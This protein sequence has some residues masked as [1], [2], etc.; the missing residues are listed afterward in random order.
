MF[1]RYRS[2]LNL[3]AASSI[4]LLPITTIS[5]TPIDAGVDQIVT[6]NAVT[7]GATP[8]V[9][10]QWQT[11]SPSD[12]YSNFTDPNL[13]AT[14]VT[15]LL[16]GD[17]Y[18][19]WRSG[20][21]GFPY[22]DRVKVTYNQDSDMDGIPDHWEL[23]HGFDPQHSDVSN[24][25]D[26][27]TLSNLQE[28]QKGTDPRSPDTD[29]DGAS[30]EIDPW[31]L[32]T[33]YVLDSD[34]D[35]IP[36][37]VERATETDPRRHNSNDL[38]HLDPS[39]ATLDYDDDTVSNLEEFLQGTDIY[40]DDTDH[41]GARDDVDKW[42]LNANYQ[43]DTDNDGLP[44]A[45]ENA[46]SFLNHDNPDDA[47]SDGDNDNLNTLTEFLL[48]TDI[49]SSDSDQDFI[50][51]GHDLY[52]LDPKSFKDEDQDGLPNGW[53]ESQGYRDDD[54]S[55]A[56]Q[57][58]DSF[59][60]DQ[61]CNYQEYANGTSPFIADP[62]DSDFDGLHDGWED[63][64]GLDKTN[65]DDAHSRIKP[66]DSMVD[67]DQD[68]LSNLEEY[69]AGTDPNYPDS[70]RDGVFDGEDVW[71]MNGLY[72]ADSDGD[73]LPDA[74]EIAFGD[75][76]QNPEISLPMNYMEPMDASDDFDGDTLTNL[77]E[78][79]LGTNP[80]HVNSDNDPV[81]DG[82]DPWPTNAMYFEDMDGDGLPAQWEILQGL[83]DQ[84]VFDASLDFD[85]DYL[86]NLQ[87]FKL[88]TDPH[89]HDSDN[90]G[91]N[92]GED[93]DPLDPSVRFDNDFD[94][95]PESWEQAN[96]LYYDD[97]RNGF[98]DQPDQDGWL[99]YQ[100][101]ANGTSPFIA[102]PYDSDFDGVL[103]DRDT[104]PM[105]H[106][107]AVNDNDRDGIPDSCD[108]RCSMLG[109]L[110]DLDDDN[111]GMPDQFEV[112]NGFNPLVNDADED[113]DGDGISNV[114]EFLN[115][116]NPQDIEI[117]KAT[118]SLLLSPLISFFDE[119]INAGCGNT[120]SLHTLTITNPS[121][122][123]IEVLNTSIVG[124]AQS[125][126]RVRE[127]YNQCDALSLAPQASCDLVIVFCPTS[128]GHKAA[129]LKVETNHPIDSI[130]YAG[131]SNK[132]HP[133]EEAKRRLPP[134]MT[135]LVVKDS[136]DIPVTNGQLLENSRYTFEWTVSSYQDW[137]S[138]LLAVFD[139]STPQNANDCGLYVNN[140]ERHSGF[141]NDPVISS[142]SWIYNGITINSFTYTYDYITPDVDGSSDVVIRFYQRS[143]NDIDAGNSSL[144]LLM[145][146][147]IDANFYGEG[148]RR[149]IYNIVDQ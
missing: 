133:G 75:P 116:T 56:C 20:P 141:L 71:P 87:E 49:Q 2:V 84:V 32:K 15:N 148:G 92:D 89:N 95:M 30:D 35:G 10:G 106:V 137:L 58:N 31:P 48:G 108:S 103:D 79:V 117:S 76:Q 52:P 81:N 27:D 104:Y 57:T 101:Y 107:L 111:D 94:G 140:Y 64:R 19:I 124:V 65:P 96:G 99:N 8:I 134:I 28:Y 3:L 86:T 21:S 26:G 37:S 44:N 18:F 34:D 61:Y 46:Y 113:V 142:G 149:L 136:F 63:S 91:V 38:Q 16:V 145:P 102:D 114:D 100:E 4:T 9:G 41:D 82:L 126:Y 78:F 74:Y 53:E 112:E 132:E 109:M 80:Y 90:D 50:L 22:V 127:E 62:Y 146:G 69:R 45:Y 5:A 118:D 66:Y 47:F 13:A 125:E 29:K 1:I 14:T 23:A 97:A 122:Q 98:E 143:Q 77:E 135:G 130:L 105:I 59:D 11:Y 51:D 120:P 88:G 129:M 131:L 138:T 24:D 83:S 40:E 6:S 123:T 60:H 54:A 33:L 17:S 85:E 115:G 70:D 73:G 93:F 72:S 36:D 68:G 128:S 67:P 55:D 12:N 144:S 39:D 42:P 121:D 7:L 110:E 119:P 147:S 43:D 25:F 139:C